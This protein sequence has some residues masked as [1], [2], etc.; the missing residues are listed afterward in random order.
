[1]GT[2][3]S[4][5]GAAGNFAD[6]SA[7]V[8][9]VAPTAADDAVLQATT[10]SMTINTGSV[11]RSLDAT[12]FTGTLTHTAGVT[13]AIGDGT[14]GAGNVA[15][16]FGTFTYTLGNAATSAI[17][18][19][20]TS[21]TVQTINFNGKTTGNVTFNA[22]SNGSWQYTGGHVCGTTAVVNLTKGTLDINGQTCSWG[23]FLSDSGSTR[24]LIL[25]AASI[26]ITKGSF[27]DVWKYTGN[28]TS[29]SAA[30]STI[31]FSGSTAQ[32][33]GPNGTYGSIVFTGGSAKIATWGSQT[34]ENLTFTGTASKTIT[35]EVSA[36]ITVTG[37][38]TINGNSS[39]NRVLFYSGTLGS[40]RT[41][42]A[43][44]IS[45]SNAD[46]QDITAAGAASWNLSAQTDI[47]DCGGNSGITFPASVTQTWSGT[48][49]GNWS[50]NAWTTRVPLPQDDVVINA[51]FSA[52]QTVTADMP[53]LGRSIDWTGATGSPS[54]GN[55]VAHSVFGSITLVSGMTISGTN[56][57]TLAGR[58]SFT[59]TSSGVVYSQQPTLAAPSGTYTLNDALA[60]TANI[61]ITTG[62][63]VTSGFDVTCSRFT[64][65]T[66]STRTITLSTTII[67]T[68]STTTAATVDL[69]GGTLNFSGESATFNI[70]GA[71]SNTR[72]FSGFGKTFG[73]LTY[74]VAGSTGKL[75]ITGSNTF[76]TLNFSD[77]TN[78]RTL[79]F[80]AG[81]T[82]T[83]NN[84]NVVGTAGKLM[85]IT[86]AS[87]ATHTL[88][89]A[90][91]IVSIDYVSISYSIAGGGARWYAGANSANGGNNTGW[92]FTPPQLGSGTR[93][94]SVSSLLSIKSF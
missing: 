33:G 79:E 17:S 31:T 3:L 88:S 28:N 16:A 50:T 85:T 36:P 19:I 55:S 53:R 2:I 87:S 1:M 6:G 24:S 91:G 42:T 64:S 51:A 90:S 9:G 38:L 76:D 34:C 21:A 62:T 72:T 43:A 45:I 5:A 83:I 77:A 4:V 89:K 40:A 81:T 75:T 14:A 46:F 23:S 78:A 74:T 35:F 37:N 94:K 73:T 82:N 12:L 69:A 25:G 10:T 32:M 86:S 57:L 54:W 47:G 67:T 48:S 26:T 15:L 56:A 44:N 92:I 52:S 84:F 27:S 61:A 39:I 22:T 70:T 58:G 59:L 41:L 63:F 80:T 65:N 18:F 71:T 68:V 29:L 13:L 60:T 66:S 93:G 49:G 8:G 7:W 30:S 20:S 11:C